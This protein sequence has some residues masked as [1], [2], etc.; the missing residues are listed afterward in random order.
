MLPRADRTPV[1]NAVRGRTADAG[2]RTV[3]VP[4]A[5]TRTV[6]NGF[7]AAAGSPPMVSVPGLD[8][9]V[10]LLLGGVMVVVVILVYFFVRYTL[11]NLREGYEEGYRDR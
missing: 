2:G 5:T 8:D 1:G 3:D 10:F 11:V 6:R 4:R 7:A 9:P